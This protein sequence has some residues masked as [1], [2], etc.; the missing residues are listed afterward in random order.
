MKKW[1]FKI[2]TM[3]R[4]PQFILVLCSLPILYDWVF[5]DEGARFS[6]FLAGFNI[7]A[8]LYWELVLSA[9]ERERGY[10]ELCTDLLGKSEE[11][12]RI[13]QEQR[14]ALKIKVR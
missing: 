10:R 13:I 8:A 1:F 14:E 5:H 7:G 6:I 2:L 9:Q 12:H 3:D 11:Y 4:T